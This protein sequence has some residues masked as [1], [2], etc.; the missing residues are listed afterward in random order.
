MR[1]SCVS[2]LTFMITR[3][4]ST[5]LCGPLDVGQTSQCIFRDIL[6]LEAVVQGLGRKLWVLTPLSLLQLLSKG[7]AVHRTLKLETPLDP[8]TE[9]FRAEVLTRHRVEHLHLLCRYLFSGPRSSSF[10]F[11]V[12][13]S[14]LKYLDER[15]LNFGSAPGL[16]TGVEGERQWR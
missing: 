7:R 16:C 4:S 9:S 10:F 14:F 2:L 11:S 8:Q 15:I 5:W 6:V 12:L 1:F 13:G 3:R